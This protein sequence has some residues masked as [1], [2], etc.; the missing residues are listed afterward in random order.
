M[1][2]LKNALLSFGAG[3]WAQGLVHTKQVLQYLAASQT[4]WW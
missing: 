1:F 4:P 3:D 2:L